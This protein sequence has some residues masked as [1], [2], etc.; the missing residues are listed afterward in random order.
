[1]SHGTCWNDWR[2]AEVYREY[3]ERYPLYPALNRRLAALAELES[4]KRVLDLGC[5]TG[6][7]TAACLELLSASAEV[8]AVDSAAVMVE[9]AR[10]HIRDRRV[11]LRCGDVGDLLGPPLGSVD[12]AVCNA[13]LWL[14]PRPASVLA[15]LAGLLEPDGL[16][17]FSLPAERVEGRDDAPHPFQREL[18]ATLI[19]RLGSLRPSLGSTFDL[20]HI[21]EV[22]ERNSLQV[23]SVEHYRH[24]GRQ[25][26]L[27]ALMEIP[28]MAGRLTPHL[29]SEE[30]QRIVRAA[31]ARCDPDLEVEVPWVYFVARRQRAQLAGTELPSTKDRR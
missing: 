16:L 20:N 31:A 27:M 21:E 28:A 13:A 25:G 2:G 29:G 1:M 11:R 6:A 9:I 17:V 15:D 24:V 3:V 4:A 18:A 23:E 14:F 10:C 19:A 8:V 7:T 12:R 5:G 22:L 30:G 26:E